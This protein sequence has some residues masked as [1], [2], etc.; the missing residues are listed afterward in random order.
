MFLVT[1]IHSVT[2]PVTVRAN[3]SSVVEVQVPIVLIK[4]PNLFKTNIFQYAHVLRLIKSQLI[5]NTL[6]GVSLRVPGINGFLFRS[7]FC[8]QVGTPP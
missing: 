4:E 7:V 1:G 5:T 2:I 3:F 6:S 8:I